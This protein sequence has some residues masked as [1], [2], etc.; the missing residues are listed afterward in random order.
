MASSGR[1][2]VAGL[3]QSLA[4]NRDFGTLDKKLS[5]RVDTPVHISPHLNRREIPPPYGILDLLITSGSLS[6]QHH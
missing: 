5:K 4:M 2:G 6:E 3:S 1:D